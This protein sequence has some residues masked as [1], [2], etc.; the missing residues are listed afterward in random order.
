MLGTTRRGFALSLAGALA[1]RSQSSE[2]LAALNLAEAAA[3]I[4]ART[5]TPTELTRACLARID[6][7][8]FKL[9]CFITVTREA[10]LAQAREL[11][12][13]QRA[14][15]LRGPL[16]GIPIALKDNID[17]AGIRTTAASAVFDDRVPDSD[18]EVTF[19][20]KAAGAVII[21]KTNLHEFAMGGTSA[22]S[23]FGPVRNPWA[24]DRN[25]G[26]SSG[27][28]AAAVAADLS[29]GALGT[30]TG[31]SIRTP[32]SFC[33]VVGLK[34]TYGLV[35]IRGIIPLSV[36]LDHCGPLVRTVE[37][38]ALML[39]ALAGYDKLDIASVEHP[40]EDYSATMKQ[41]VSGL[42]LGIPRAPFFDLLDA[43]VAKAVEDAIGVLAKMTKGARDVSLPAIRDINLGGE[44]FAYHE[45]L[46]AHASGRYQ[47]PT[48]RALQNGGSLKAADY[49]R[50]RWKL[51]LLRRTIDD[52][53]ADFDL[54][55]LPTR[56]RTPRKIDAAIKREESDKPRNPE[57]ENTGQ[58]NVY[59]IPAIS[60]PC[61]FTSAGLPV[62]L[63]IAGP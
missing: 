16:H 63:M 15:K 45:E 42:R 10:A 47:I 1:A 32:A 53:F 62:G 9:N 22:T 6:T 17:T 56:R 26:G 24:L 5:V 61:G 7:Y 38:A 36:S 44:S 39:T 11:E 19:R 43:D 34:P 30:D 46:Y 25:P 8:N 41:P 49:I 59:G 21:G 13:E 14:G 33:G 35:S 48:R 29:Y 52:A 50:G 12:A 28:S 54:V 18:A 57:L 58:F 60:V 55:V 23:Y 3:R 31:G 27:G 20:L 4:R 51:E 37:D 2:D 40:K